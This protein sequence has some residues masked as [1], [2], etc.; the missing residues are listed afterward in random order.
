MT[1][2][3]SA[4]GESV[5]MPFSVE[6]KEKKASVE[7]REGGQLMI[8]QGLTEDETRIETAR[9]PPKD[10]DGLGREPHE[11]VEARVRAADLDGLDLEV[12]DKSDRR[13]HGGPSRGDDRSSLVRGEL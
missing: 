5:A 3:A 6:A 2:E 7:R 11:R 12:A 4:G 13:A 1:G 10:L 8:D 9:L